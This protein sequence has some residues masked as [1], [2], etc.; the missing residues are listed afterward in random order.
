MTPVEFYVPPIEGVAGKRIVKAH[1]MRGLSRWLTWCKDSPA[2]L[3]GPHPLDIAYVSN[4]HSRTQLWY[5]TPIREE[6]EWFYHSL[7][8]DACLWREPG[9]IHLYHNAVTVLQN[10]DDTL[11][12]IEATLATAYHYHFYVYPLP[13]SA[14]RAYMKQDDLARIP[15]DTFRT[16]DMNLASLEQALLAKDPMMPVHLRNIHA[17][18]IAYPESVHLLED[19][20][21]ASLIDAAEAHTMTKI[22]SDSAKKATTGTRATKKALANPDLGTL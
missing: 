18:I 19:K 15:A 7:S 11:E 16:L 8:Y 6:L 2:D 9:R 13:R 5:N 3:R 1:V 14:R 22:V 4:L 17:T 20:D 10:C 12:A 21:V